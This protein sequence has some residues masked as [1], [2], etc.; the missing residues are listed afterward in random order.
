ML[1]CFHFSSQEVI[2]CHT[3]PGIRTRP[4]TLILPNRFDPSFL[5]LFCPFFVSFLLLCRRDVS[6]SSFPGPSSHRSICDQAS[7]QQRFSVLALRVVFYSILS[8]HFFSSFVCSDTLNSSDVI[9]ASISLSLCFSLCSVLISTIQLF[10]LT[11]K[12]AQ[13]SFCL[14]PKNFFSPASSSSR[15]VI[16]L[17]SPP[18]PSCLH[19]RGGN[20]LFVAA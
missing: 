5:S 9:G 16:F 4:C 1:S 14:S 10:K 3:R 12:D 19:I 20:V 8:D 11:C 15:L 17:L 13:Y 6:P 7:G 2:Y 18:L